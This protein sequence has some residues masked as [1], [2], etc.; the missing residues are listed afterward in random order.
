[1]NVG[2]VLIRLVRSGVLPDPD[3][4]LNHVVN[5]I[6]L[7]GARMRLY[8][9]LGVQF[10]D[11]SSTNISLGVD[12]WLGT[13]LTMGARSTIGQRCYIDARGGIRIDSNVSVAREA[14][15]LTATHIPDA[16][17]FAGRVLP[18]HLHQR[19]WI[20]LRALVMPGVNIGEGAIVGAGA[21]V[22]SDVDPYTIV[23]GVPAK[24][25][26]K[27]RGP[28]SYELGWRPSWY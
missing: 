17:N 5:R 9:A 1:V 15:L 28:M 20:G 2:P 21:L 6:P 12:M 3:Y 7:A 13:R 27:R 23:S 24:V 18:I 26:R 11:V 22:T 8:A 19:C 14:A 4:F 16:P 10:D 25:L